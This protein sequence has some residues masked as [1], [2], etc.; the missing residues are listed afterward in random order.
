MLHLKKKTEQPNI[1]MLKKPVI[2]INVDFKKKKEHLVIGDFDNVNRFIRGQKN[3]EIIFEKIRPLGSFLLDIITE[4]VFFAD[5]KAN[6]CET[7]KEKYAENVRAVESLY[8][9]ENP[10]LKFIA[11]ELWDEYGRILKADKEKDEDY[12]VLEGM[13]DLTL[14]FRYKLINRILSWQKHKPYN[15]LIDM[16]AEYYKYPALTL[17]IPQSKGIGEYIASDFTL[18]PIIV[19]YLKII[20]EHKKYFNYC[21]VC[22]KLF[23][24]PDNNKTFIC[25]DKCKTKQQKMNKKKYDNAHKDDRTEKLHKAEYQYW[26]NR[27]SKAKRK[28]NEKAIADIE[29]AFAKFKEF[30]NIKKKQV[31]DGLLSSADYY[32]WCMEQRNIIDDIMME[33]DLFERG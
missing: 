32:G 5:I 8:E 3:I 10:V 1:P 30:S 26:F 15:P 7:S 29:K 9:S 12:P 4:P 14:P 31:N 27:I 6:F 24:A 22:G 17:V 33:H 2:A 16:G 25:S 23:L 11:L 28:N 19:H 18:L 13:E 20:Y 21:K